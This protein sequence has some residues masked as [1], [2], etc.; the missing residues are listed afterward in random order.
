[1]ENA[2]VININ[3]INIAPSVDEDTAGRYEKWVKEAYMPIIMK[4]VEITGADRYALVRSSREYPSMGV[5]RHY[6]NM[7]TF[8]NY[9]RTSVNKDINEDL[10]AW[11]KRGVREGAWSAAYEL[12]HGFRAGASFQG[13]IKDTKIENAP[14][15][16]L[17]GYRMSLEEAERFNKWFDTYS[18]VF[19]PLFIKNCGLKGYDYFKYSGLAPAVSAKE[20]EYPSHIS[21]LYFENIEAFEH[22]DRSSEQSSFQSA[23][24][25]IFPLGLNYKWYV[26]YRLTQSWRK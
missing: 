22:F 21:I 18:R 11:S 2:P 13:E 4:T 6:G 24:R 14:L 23:L 3:F 15:M 19:M 9:S 5:V 25:T 10:N 26:Q 8:E 20:T 12:V 16:H 17:E 7:V 1:M